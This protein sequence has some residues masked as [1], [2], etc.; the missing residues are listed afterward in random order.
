M[1]SDDTT[2]TEGSE[3]FDSTPGQEAQTPLTPGQDEQGDGAKELGSS[4][5]GKGQGLVDR[6][7][8]NLTTE[9]EA[10]KIK[11]FE[12]EKQAQGGSAARDS[13]EGA[14]DPADPGPEKT[15]P[16]PMSDIEQYRRMEQFL[17]KH[18]KEW[19]MKAGKPKIFGMNPKSN[20]RLHLDGKFDYGPWSYE[21]KPYS[22]PSYNRP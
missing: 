22:H 1:A 11:I 15:R 3:T 12:L 10:L 6:V 9:L 8:V 19:E 20:S 4:L 18:R 14:Q 13:D 21:W 16:D 17:Y 7:A 2:E 5:T